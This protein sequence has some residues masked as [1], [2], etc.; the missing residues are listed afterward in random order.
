VT[1][2]WQGRS[3]GLGL[4]ALAIGWTG[5]AAAEEKARLVYVRGVGAEDCPAEVDLRLL[6]MARLGYD[7]FSPQASRVVLSRIELTG[8][9]L[10]GSLEAID[11]SGISS[12]RRELTSKLGRCADLTRALAL[13]ISLAIDPERASQPVPQSP[14]P[15]PP[16]EAP[17]NQES[18][19]K[20]KPT[21]PA[22]HLKPAPTERAHAFA[23]LALAASVGSL[24]VGAVGGVISLGWRFGS[25]SIALEALAQQGFASEL[26]PRGDLT[27]RLFAGR[28]SACW[29][30]YR[31]AACGV[32]SV[33]AQLL[34]ASGV[35][36]PVTST[37]L[38]VGA[39]PRLAWIQPM[40]RGWQIATSVEGLLN[41][42]RNRAELSGSEVWRTPPVSV[43]LTVGAWASF[44]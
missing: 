44:L 38:L 37:G 23:G 39:G 21:P 33:G 13:S 36:H 25:G 43:T 19:P 2:G 14:S 7:P 42:Q 3:T 16:P 5:S 29:S 17:P 35:T 8:E 9:Q 28:A 1:R 27:G 22:A 26:S 12:G 32:G 41:L 15:T 34:G 20:P 40:E 6:V 30:Q 10:L 31:L 18:T 4:L 24:P 11:A